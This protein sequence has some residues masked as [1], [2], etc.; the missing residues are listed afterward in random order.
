MPCLGVWVSIC[1][2][3]GCFW[4]SSSSSSSSFV[5]LVFRFLSFFLICCVLPFPILSHWF[6]FVL[7]VWGFSCVIFVAGWGGGGSSS[8]SFVDLGRPTPIFFHMALSVLS[9]SLPLSLYL[10]I[11]IYIYISLSLSLTHSLSPFYHPHFLPNFVDLHLLINT[12]NKNTKLTD[13]KKGPITVKW[14]TKSTN[15]KNSEIEQQ[16]HIQTT[17]THNRIQRRASPPMQPTSQHTT[18]YKHKEVQQSISG[19]TEYPRHTQRTQ[20]TKTQTLFRLAR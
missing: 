17:H 19:W 20:I 8:S 5:F 14:Q 1:F 11:Y 9:C 18:T 10:Y 6:W 16:D 4:A 13:N 12:K 2:S 15:N 7:G 3:F